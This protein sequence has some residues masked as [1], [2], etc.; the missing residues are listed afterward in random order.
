MGA[1]INTLLA[2]IFL[3][4]LSLIVSNHYYKIYF[5]NIKLISLLTIG[6]V[7]F[8]LTYFI[9]IELLWI[10]LIFKVLLVIAF[11]LILYLTSF[12]EPKEIRLIKG[13]IK[14]WR[15]PADWIDNLRNESKFF[16]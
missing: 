11:P 3:Y 16:Q 5:E 9:Q 7:L 2:F 6:T 12:Y 14:K 13:F 1:A 8:S 15:S 10:N 4:F